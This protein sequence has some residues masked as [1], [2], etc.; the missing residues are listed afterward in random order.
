[1]LLHPMK[2]DELGTFFFVSLLESGEKTHVVF[3]TPSSI[4]VD[5][6][7]RNDKK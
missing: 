6:I 4:Q 7:Y 5:V 2:W 1:M 3:F